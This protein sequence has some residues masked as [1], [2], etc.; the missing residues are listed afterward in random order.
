MANQLKKHIYIIED[1][2]SLR[3][4]LCLLLENLGFEVHAF[5]NPLLMLSEN[6]YPDQ[7]ILLSDMKMPEISG[8]DLLAKLK[9]KNAGLLVILMSGYFTHFEKTQAIKSG[10]A[11]LLSKP[12]EVESLLAVIDKAIA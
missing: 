2:D 11:A 9:S 7:A 1:D 6:S 4:S 8:L 5:S 12:F 10:A 3:Q